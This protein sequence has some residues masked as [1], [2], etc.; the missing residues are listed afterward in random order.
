MDHRDEPQREQ[1]R[2]VLLGCP[3]CHLEVLAL[4]MS[5]VWCGSC[6]SAPQLERT[7]T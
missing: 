1:A 6:P 4:P 2:L 3:L 7:A 5:L